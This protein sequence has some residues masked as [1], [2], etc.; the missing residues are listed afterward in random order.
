[1]QDPRMQ[2]ANRKLIGLLVI[3]CFA[4]A[5][6]ILIICISLNSHENV[7]SVR[8]AKRVVIGM[9]FAQVTALLG[10]PRDETFGAVI[11]KEAEWYP[12]FIGEYRFTNSK[13]WISR[14]LVIAVRF[15]RLSGRVTSCEHWE[16][17]TVSIP[18]RGINV[19]DF[20]K[21]INKSEDIQ[22]A[23]VNTTVSGGIIKG[24][25]RK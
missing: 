10:P 1:M 15:N 22:P 11:N 3:T 18:F 6:G 14:D 12:P 13:Y 8:S 7:L 16:P 24:R 17:E 21:N 25:T 19:I 2:H 23:R 5:T 20:V 9:T 4:I